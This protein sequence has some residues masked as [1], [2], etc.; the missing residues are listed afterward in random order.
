[1]DDNILII[2]HDPDIRR[3]LESILTGT[4]YRVESASGPAEAILVFKRQR[5]SLVVMETRL[6]GQS[7]QEL[8]RLFKKMD[9]D[10]EVIVLTGNATLVNAVDAMRGDGAF[11]F[12]TKP[13]EDVAQLIRSVDQALAKQRSNRERSRLFSHMNGHGSAPSER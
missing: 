13:L 5:P 11:D 12:L 3:Y 10:V 7:G 9:A 1:M 4:G 6:E 2:D 8:I